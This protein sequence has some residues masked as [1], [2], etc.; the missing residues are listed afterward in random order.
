MVEFVEVDPLRHPVDDC[1]ITELITEIDGEPRM[2][3]ISGNITVVTL[4]SN[5]SSA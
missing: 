4:S 2:E 3:A 5:A 1:S